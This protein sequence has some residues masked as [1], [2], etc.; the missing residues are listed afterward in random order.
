MGRRKDKRMWCVKCGKPVA[1]HELM[2]FTIDD[3]SGA[4]IKFHWHE[5]CVDE[6]EEAQAMFD[7]DARPPEG[8]S[9]QE[10]IEE[11]TRRYD[12][13]VVAIWKR[14]AEAEGPIKG[15]EVRRDTTVPEHTY[16]LSSRWG[17]LTR[18]RRVSPK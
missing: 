14:E 11:F 16:R 9:K 7:F 3:A 17:M 2:H 5:G 10:Q 13:L 1:H 12:A 15:L 8:L 18:V 6:D 4:C